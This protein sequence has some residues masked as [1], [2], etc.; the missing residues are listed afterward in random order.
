[1]RSRPVLSNSHRLPFRSE[2]GHWLGLASL[3]PAIVL[4]IDY[5]LLDSTLRF[6]TSHLANVS[7]S[8][9]ELSTHQIL[10][11][12]WNH[13]FRHT[14]DKYKMPAPLLFILHSLSH[15]SSYSTISCPLKNSLN[16]IPLP[17]LLSSRMLSSTGPSSCRPKTTC[18]QTSCSPSGHFVALQTTLL[19][20][21]HSF[22]SFTRLIVDR[23]H[24]QQ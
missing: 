14:P 1:V 23:I 21:L 6:F 22:L 13:P 7:R 4:V 3:T 20:V 9:T 5:H 2:T 15:N 11:H 24:Q 17:I 16:R 10:E 12:H 19:L 18:L 8:Q